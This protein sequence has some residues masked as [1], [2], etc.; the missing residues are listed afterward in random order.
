[1]SRDEKRRVIPGKPNPIDN[2]LR[3]L[4]AIR[5]NQMPPSGGSPKRSNNSSFSPLLSQFLPTFSDK[6]E[7]NANPRFTLTPTITEGINTRG[8]SAPINRVRLETK[9]IYIR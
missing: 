2:K 5:S 3:K 9:D 6:A 7:G 1:L 4:Q 8:T